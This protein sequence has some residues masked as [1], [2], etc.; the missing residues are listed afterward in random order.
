MQLLLPIQNALR[1]WRSVWQLTNTLPTDPV[2]AINADDLLPD[3]M[4][5]RYGFWKYCFEYWLF[6]NLVVGS[7]SNL[8]DSPIDDQ[9]E[10]GQGD[11][12]YLRDD[13]VDPIL[14]KYDQTSMRQVNDLISSFQNCQIW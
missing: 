4:W 11:S 9:A 5:E 3:K 10:T 6:A 8:Y 14:N 2:N 7:I 1:N 13:F 12:E